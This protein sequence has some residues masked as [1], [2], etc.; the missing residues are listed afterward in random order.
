MLEGFVQAD[1]GSLGIGMMK[2]NGR[3]LLKCVV[4]V[5]LPLSG[6]VLLSQRLSLD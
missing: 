4:P 2:M 1:L 6:G 3:S 5:A